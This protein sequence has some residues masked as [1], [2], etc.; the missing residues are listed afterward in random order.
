MD[1]IYEWQNDINKKKDE[2]KKVLDQE[3]LKSILDV[4]AIVKPIN[5]D[6]VSKIDCLK[7]ANC[8]KTTVTTFN[9]EDINKASKFIGVS[10]KAFIKKFLI[11]DMG[12]FTT[13][14]TPCPFLQEDNKCGIYEVR[15]LACKSFP[16]THKKSFLS[17]KQS[18]ENNYLVCPI[19]YH[20][21]KKLE[22]IV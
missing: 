17:R 12:E 18:H 7:C 14:N 10:K 9:Q 19:T 21:I 22:K 13:I 5:D 16:H 8:C 3:G 1:L 6:I 20:I 11:L 15:P 4:D 2:A